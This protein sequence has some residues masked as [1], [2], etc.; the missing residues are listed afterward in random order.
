MR[1]FLV[2]LFVLVSAPLTVLAQSDDR[3]NTILVLDG[4]GSMWG[5]IDGVNK[6]TI[7]QG[8]I[9][10]LLA[11]MPDDQ[12]LGLTVYGHNRRGDCSDIET[13]VAPAPGSQEEILAAVNAINPRGRTPMSDAVVA[14]AEAL[15]HTENAATVILVSD[16]IETCDADPCAI[17]AELEAAGIG[18][19]AHVV[20]FDVASEPAARAQ[21][22]CIAE[23]T[24]GLFLTADNADELSDALEQ[25]VMAPVP[26]PMRLEAQV[27][28]DR[29]LPTRPVTWE[30]LDGTGAVL[31]GPLSGGVVDVELMAGDYTA[32]ATR[33]EPD[34]AV[35]YQAAFTV[36]QDQSDLVIVEMPEIIETAEVTFVARLGDEAGAVITDPVIW[37]MVPT[38]ADNSF[39][40]N[41]ITENPTRL[42]MPRGAY[43]VTAYWTVGEVEQSTDFVV[44]DQPREIVLVFEAPRPQASLTAPPEA[45]AGSMIDVEWEGPGSPDD[46]IGIG[47][48]GETGNSQWRNYTYTREGS[49]LPLLVPP[50]AGDY[51]IR[52]FLSA[53]REAIAET[54]IRVTEAPATIT[55]PAEA[56]AGSTVEIGWTGPD[57]PDDYIG[58]GRAGETGGR[59]WEN[60]TYT[61]E[62]SPLSLLIPTEPG[63]YVIRYFLSQDRTP[64]AETPITVS[65]V[66]ASVTAPAE[67]VAGSTIEVGWTGP[68][69]PDDYIGIG[70]AGETGG[71]SWEN[72][73]YTRDGAPLMLEVPV[74][75]G[76]Y[77]IQYFLSQDRT[78]IAQTQINVL[79]VEASVTAPSD[80]VAGSTIEV[81][82]TGPDYDDDY[83]GIGRVGETGGGAW[84]NYT[85]TREGSP[86]PLLIPAEPGAYVIQYFLRQDRTPISETPIR[87]APVAASVTAPATAKAGDML[88]V[89]WTGPDYRGDYIGIGRAGETGGRQWEEFTRT[90]EGNPVMLQMPDMP[91]DYV[92]RYFLDQDRTPVAEVPITLQ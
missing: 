50:E 57:Y 8:V 83:I 61:R 49:P 77:V 27:L 91:G 52:Y 51:V 90:R 81:T 34:G 40:S 3:P 37:T 56:M 92:I 25:V 35:E 1:A 62:G 44:V 55:A 5:Q 82:W 2:A 89:G 33:A 19:T 38:S 86:L 32:R 28:P 67:A 20:G 71:R 63:E 13:L 66:Q 30:V 46:Y 12:S 4:S 22:Q 6:I 11:D 17:A 26:T 78:P 47:L 70:R 84:E 14:A 65:E 75:P 31:L 18:F 60:Y 24:G 36:V 79:P 54:P 80:A 41:P 29:S 42:T 39:A 59:S 64:I 16:G 85:Y 15:R 88:E 7:A 23:N 68:D 10:D 21:M 87:V 9:A 72:Y 45:V 53:D 58:I 69:N 48:A 74:T 73:T 76:A 43:T